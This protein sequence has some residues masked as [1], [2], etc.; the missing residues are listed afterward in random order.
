MQ[1]LNEWLKKAM[2]TLNEKIAYG[3]NEAVRHLQPA[4]LR[5]FGESLKNLI[6]HQE[7]VITTYSETSEEQKARRVQAKKAREED[8]FLEEE[9]GGKVEG[10]ARGLRSRSR[11][12]VDKA[13]R[14]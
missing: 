8:E 14:A 6:P 11:S 7:E 3:V 4:P 1:A 13:T 10:S 2:D 12:P 5:L 9:G